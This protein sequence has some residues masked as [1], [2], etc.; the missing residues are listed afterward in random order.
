VK[1][2]LQVIGLSFIVLSLALAMVGLIVLGNSLPNERV[3]DCSMAEFH[4]DYPL[5]VREE[6]RKLRLSKSI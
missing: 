1:Q 3:Y 6:C 2:T 5:Q 4:P